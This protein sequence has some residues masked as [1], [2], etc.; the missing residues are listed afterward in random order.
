M[1]WFN[2]N[3]EA[4]AAAGVALEAIKKA[5]EPYIPFSVAR[6]HVLAA[7]DRLYTA[8]IRFEDNGCEITEGD[9]YLHLFDALAM[10]NDALHRWTGDR[11]NL[12]RAQHSLNCVLSCAVPY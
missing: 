2:P 11:A 12:E 10:L 7:R 6:P 8:L 3:Q 1:I 5:F 9:L 4:H